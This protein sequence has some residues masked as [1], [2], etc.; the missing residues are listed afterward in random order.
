MWRRSLDE[1][2]R[3]P[4]AKVDDQALFDGNEDG[5]CELGSPMREHTE[6]DPVGEHTVLDPAKSD[7][8]A[9]TEEGTPR[10]IARASM[11]EGRLPTALHLVSSFDLP[12]PVGL[13]GLILSPV[14]V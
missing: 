13:S 2:N 5:T 1:S 6:R 10:M 9:H 8:P 4:H 14:H 11:M 7:E 12:F 3:V